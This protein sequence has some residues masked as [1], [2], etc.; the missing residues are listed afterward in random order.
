MNF[1]FKFHASRDLKPRTDLRIDPHTYFTLK[2]SD[3]KINRTVKPLN[4]FIFVIAQL[5]L[6]IPKDKVWCRPQT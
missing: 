2:Q 6:M 4:I 3:H 1:D 5:F